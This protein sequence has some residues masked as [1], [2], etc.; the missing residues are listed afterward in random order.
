MKS[1]VV[2]IVL[3]AS[4]AAAT[5]LHGY[6]TKPPA[7]PDKISRSLEGARKLLPP[8]SRISFKGEAAKSELLSWAR[9]AMAPHFL[10]ASN[11]YDTT[12]TIRYLTKNDSVLLLQ[13]NSHGIFWQ[14]SDS[15]YHYSLSTVRNATK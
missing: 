1:Y 10:D 6:R 3:A 11:T 7:E 9:Y 12:L 4:V 13:E 14:Q 15:V 5:A 2:L 8:G